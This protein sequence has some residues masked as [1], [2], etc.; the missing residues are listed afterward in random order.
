LVTSKWTHQAR[1]VRRRNLSFRFSAG[2]RGPDQS[3]A[4]GLTRPDVR[5]PLLVSGI[6]PKFPQLLLAKC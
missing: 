1:L 4:G 5:L 2:F 6:N 3:T